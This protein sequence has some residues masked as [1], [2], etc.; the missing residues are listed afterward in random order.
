MLQIGT[1]PIGRG[2]G[3]SDSLA[4]VVAAAEPSGSDSLVS[5]G[6]SMTATEVPVTR[7]PLELFLGHVR[8][9]NI[10]LVNTMMDEVLDINAAITQIE[11]PALMIA[12]QH[13]HLEIAC[14]LLK[15]PLI[16]VNWV[17]AGLFSAFYHA[18][19][20]NRLEI[21]RIMGDDPRVDVNR[22]QS[23]NASPLYV[24]CER[25]HVEIVGH[26][27]RHPRVNRNVMMTGGF[28]VFYVACSHGNL[29]VAKSLLAAN[30]EAPCKGTDPNWGKD[31]GATPIFIASQEGHTEVVAWLLAQPEINVMNATRQDATALYVACEKGRVDV[32]SM[33]LADRRV[34]PHVVMEGNFTPLY[35]AC[36][37]NAADAVRLL[38]A[39]GR[40]DPNISNYQGASPL[41]VASQ[42]GNNDIVRMLL[43]DPRVRFDLC[44]DKGSTPLAI[45]CEQGHLETVKLLVDDGRS[46]LN[47][48]LKNGATPFYVACEKGRLEVVRYL[49]AI[50]EVDVHLTLEGG[51]TP[52]YVACSYGRTEV[53]DFLLCD[54]RLD[55]RTFNT[56][57][58]SPFFIAAQQGHPGVLRLL[59]R[60]SRGMTTLE[61]V[62]RNTAQPDRTPFFL[63]VSCGR[64]D[65]LREIISAGVP[66]SFSRLPNA[67]VATHV[68][69]A[70]TAGHA[71][72]ADLLRRFWDDRE[73]TVITV[74]RQ[75]GTATEQAAWV[76]ALAVF[77]SDAFLVLRKRRQ[78]LPVTR[79][80]ARRFFVQAKKLPLEVVMV[81]CNAVGNTGRTIVRSEESERAFRR[82]IVA[83][84]NE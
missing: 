59:A 68:A 66:L 57:G 74:R 71:E 19:R 14:V 61:A 7:T 48:T 64:V 21:V 10:D 75:I 26:L 29:E 73:G 46:S 15:H 23:Q 80:R 17:S 36:S 69:A 35:V 78:G 65:V 79:A 55:P 82:I 28:N 45:A 3:E 37:H 8:A 24:A 42:S 5:A 9:G 34:N 54:G 70:R 62:P 44:T 2:S 33:L 38:L 53:V 40:I 12:V 49:A 47:T 58:C 18:C 22:C 31:D 77:Y 4:V 76:F 16:D 84:D 1:V 13:G 43:K 27:L 83:F 60:D 56:N 51:Y 39:D 11:G 63:G 67:E 25:G 41:F 50:R 20:M 72:V 6:P 32:V 52:L 30:R 81:L